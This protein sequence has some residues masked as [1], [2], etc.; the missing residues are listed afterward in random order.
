MSEWVFLRAGLLAGHSYGELMAVQA[1]P[2][3]LVDSRPT[4]RAVVLVPAFTEQAP[5]LAGLAG[6]RSML[7]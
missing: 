7:C 5:V 1:D 4:V 6:G 2:G 3:T